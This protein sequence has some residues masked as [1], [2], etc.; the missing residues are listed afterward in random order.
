MTEAPL[1]LAALPF[2][3]I[4][5]VAISIGPVD[6]RWYGLAYLAGLILGWLYMRGLARNA[7]LWRGASPV[8]ALQVDDFLIWAT[9]GVVV[10]GRLGFVL[11]YQPGYFLAHP[12][13]ILAVWGGGMSFH[14]GLLGVG[15]AT[16]IFA[17][18]KGIPLFSL[19]D[20]AAAATPFG[21]FFGRIANFI[22]GEIYGRLSDVPWAVEF[23]QRVLDAGHVLGPRHPTQIYEAML[24]GVVLFAVLRY[25]THWR[26]ALMRPGIV[27]GTF[28]MGYGA[29]R[30]F[31]E[32]A[33][34]IW[35]YDFSILGV[36][37]SVGTVYSLPMIALGLF[38]VMH[39][40]RQDRLATQ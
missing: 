5:P 21:L 13:E 31:V 4:D 32:F 3:N 24:E 30:I 22:N 23:P 19:M 7:S 36:E 26:G 40:L 39:A 14:G 8:N 38:F 16:F 35:R 28:L 25:L 17:R 37:I 34:K 33:G 29:A 20:L 2:P 1:H 10:G 9:L 11:F 6:I 12:A 15:L 18:A 27:V